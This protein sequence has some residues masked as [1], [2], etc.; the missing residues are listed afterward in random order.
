MH[1]QSKR[2]TFEEILE[3][4]NEKAIFVNMEVKFDKLPN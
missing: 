4:D 1:C 3:I 2:N